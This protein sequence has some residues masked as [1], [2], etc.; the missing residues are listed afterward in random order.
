MCWGLPQN[1]VDIL[2][3]STSALP[4]PQN[5]CALKGIKGAFIIETMARRC[6]TL[7]ESRTRDANAAISSRVGPSLAQLRKSSRVPILHPSVYQRRTIM[8]LPLSFKRRYCRLLVSGVVLV[9][10]VHT[11][12]LVRYPFQDGLRDTDSAQR[13]AAAHPI[14]GLI[15]EANQKW[16]QLLSK[17]VY[18]LPA[19]SEEYRKRRRRHPP[20]GFDQWFSFAQQKEAVIIE[21][22]FDQIYEDLSP[23]WGMNPKEMRQ[24]AKNSDL[25]II[26]RNHTQT[27]VGHTGVSWLETWM[28]MVGTIAEW[29]PD[30]DIPLNGIPNG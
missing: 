9:T 4:L 27:S 25:R 10:V 23:Y 30:M 14:D 6:T 5:G 21:D 12:S 13:G 28:D 22:L 29:L 2:S 1:D 11:F 7:H 17:Q 26:L 15:H 24:H 19:A 20:P 16:E 3:M 18:Q 8:L